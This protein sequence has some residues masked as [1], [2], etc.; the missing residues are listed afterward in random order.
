MQEEALAPKPPVAKKKAAYPKLLINETED[1]GAEIA[2]T[3]SPP[4][5]KV[6]PV[7]SERAYHNASTPAPFAPRVLDAAQMSFVMTRWQ[8]LTAYIDL[9]KEREELRKRCEEEY[10]NHATALLLLVD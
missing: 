7:R 2:E 3:L 6:P 8:E 10:N 4:L 9:A 5:K 1:G